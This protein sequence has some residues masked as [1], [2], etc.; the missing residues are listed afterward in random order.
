MPETPEELA[1]KVRAALVTHYHT[2]P[3]LGP[4][5]VEREANAALDALLAHLAEAG[6]WGQ[7][8]HDALDG[9]PLPE[10]PDEAPARIAALLADRDRYRDALRKAPMPFRESTL[11][12]AWDETYD[13]WWHE[14]A[15]E[16][17][18]DPEQKGENER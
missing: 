18:L 7:Q 16:A 9:Q 3:D 13:E 2:V 17:A 8:V 4:S 11:G 1:E 15:S 5:R 14:N 12:D 10:H 6:R